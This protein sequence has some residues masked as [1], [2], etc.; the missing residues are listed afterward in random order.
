MKDPAFLHFSFLHSPSLSLSLSP[1]DLYDHLFSERGFHP[2]LF[3]PKKA[4]R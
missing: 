2:A 1:S 3:L 4:L